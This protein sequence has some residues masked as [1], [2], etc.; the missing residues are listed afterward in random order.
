M[1]YLNNIT[2]KLDNAGYDT[3]GFNKY[4]VTVQTNNGVRPTT[5][6]YNDDDK[7]FC[8]YRSKWDD[9]NKINDCINCVSNYGFYG[10]RQFYCDGKCMARYDTGQVC[11]DGSLVARNISINFW[12][13]NLQQ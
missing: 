11:S 3:T 12:N 1:S 2:Q 7:K 5:N 13:T 4:A 6:Y 8:N 9:E 10:Q